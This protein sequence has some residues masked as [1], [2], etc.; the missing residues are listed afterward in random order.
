[1]AYS[2]IEVG[3]VLGG[4]HV[5]QRYQDETEHL[6]NEQKSANNKSGGHR[7]ASKQAHCV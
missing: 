6:I 2:H 4:S 7:T 1:M 5:L 3:M